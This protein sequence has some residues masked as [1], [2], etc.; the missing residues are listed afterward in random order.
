[1]LCIALC[2]Y[3]VLKLNDEFTVRYVAPLRG[4]RASPS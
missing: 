1:M 4:A 3:A 2:M